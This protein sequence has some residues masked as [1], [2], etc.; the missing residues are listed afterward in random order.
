MYK[1]QPSQGGETYEIIYQPVR[2]TI[3]KDS[4]VR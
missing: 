1:D 4:L 3:Q 2:D